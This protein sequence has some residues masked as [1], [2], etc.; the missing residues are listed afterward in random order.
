MH[1]GFKCLDISSGCIYISRDVIFDKNVCPFASLH[2]NVGTRY[3][4]DILF[5]P[6]NSSGDNDFANMTNAPA[7]SILP[8]P[9]AHVPLQRRVHACHLFQVRLLSLM[10]S[11]LPHRYQYQSLNRPLLK[12][13]RRMIQAVFIWTL[14]RSLLACPWVR[15]LAPWSLHRLCQRHM[16]WAV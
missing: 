16:T 15:L 5:F 12:P 3:H 10:L 9:N 2:T 4:S 8:V 14:L 1:K 7:L 6:S 11:H 13:Q